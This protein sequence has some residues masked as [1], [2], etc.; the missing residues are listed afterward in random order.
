[1]SKPSSSVHCRWRYFV[2]FVAT[3]VVILVDLRGGSKRNEE[4]AKMK[5]KKKLKRP[6]CCSFVRAQSDWG[7]ATAVNTAS[8]FDLFVRILVCTA[9]HNLFSNLFPPIPFSLR[10]FTNL[11]PIERAPLLFL[12][13]LPLALPFSHYPLPPFIGSCRMWCW[14]PSC[15]CVV[16]VSTTSFFSFLLHLC[17]LVERVETTKATAAQ[18]NVCVWLVV[19]GQQAEEVVHQEKV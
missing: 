12:F 13:L 7:S 3:T 9:S 11:P 6:C 2:L 1:M 16:S 8:L 18:H 19:D 15:C 17:L 14:C 5:R 10:S 4:R